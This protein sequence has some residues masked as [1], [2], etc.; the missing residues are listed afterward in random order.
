MPL[1]PPREV[2]YRHPLERCTKDADSK[3]AVTGFL[4][5]YAPSF[6]GHRVRVE[7]RIRT[8]TECANGCTIENAHNNGAA[9]QRAKGKPRSGVFLP[10]SPPTENATRALDEPKEHR[11][12]KAHGKYT[13]NVMHDPSPPLRNTS[14]KA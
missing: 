9:S 1:S 10:P 6:F 13:H 11:R 3:T 5:E 4:F 14:N 8:D 7:R 12:D 2:E